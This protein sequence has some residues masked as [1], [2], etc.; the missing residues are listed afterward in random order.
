MGPFH[1]LSF[2]LTLDVVFPG[3][4]E[5]VVELGQV[6]RG[7]ACRVFANGVPLRPVS[8]DQFRHIGLI[9]QA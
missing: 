7:H 4:L 2:T 9:F 3:L 8:P 6:R 5:Q 1:N